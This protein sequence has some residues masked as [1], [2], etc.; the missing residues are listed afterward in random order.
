MHSAHLPVHY[1]EPV[2]RPPSEAD[3]LILQATLGCSWNRCAFCEMYR[4]KPFRPRPHDE[5]LREIHAVGACNRHLRRVFLGDGDA[6]VLSTR[7]L[8]EILAAIRTALPSV[9]RVT[10]YAT[11]ANLLAK[12][13]DELEALHH[14]GLGMVYVGIES[15][16]DEVL[17]RI[18]KGATQAETIAALQRAGAAGFTRSVMIINGLGGQR[19]SDLHADASAAVLNAV[20]PEYAAVLALT[21]PRGDAR[22]R[23]A[24]G[25]KHAPL[26]DLQLLQEL[27]RLLDACRLEGT[28]FR[29]N[30]ASNLIALAG[31]LDRDRER[32]LG[33][34]DAVIAR[35]GRDVRPHWARSL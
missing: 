10:C 13:P 30:H 23:A 9:E 32:L 2:Y 24:F 8:L 34:L 3:S 11:P 21:T 14:A 12:R 33:E 25:D 31:L 26:D 29:S 15:G 20:Q 27:R 18:D 5:L 22:M 28:V 1:E 35:Q 7:R 16:D 4:N 17:A 6:L 19:Y